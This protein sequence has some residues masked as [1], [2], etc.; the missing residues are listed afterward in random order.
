MEELNPAGI[1]ISVLLG[2]ATNNANGINLAT[3]QLWMDP[4]RLDGR[5]S[6]LQA[7]RSIRLYLQIWSGQPTQE[8]AASKAVSSRG[9]Q[10]VT[11]CG[12]MPST[13]RPC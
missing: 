1:P 11:A 9:V 5:C 10:A 12:A 2:T 7:A 13:T 6:I 8:L 3:P 4:V